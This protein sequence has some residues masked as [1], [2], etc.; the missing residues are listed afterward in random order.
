M[1]DWISLNEGEPY[2]IEGKHWEGGGAEYFS[3]AVEIENNVLPGHH[4]AIREQQYLGVT[5]DQQFD[6]TRITITD[7]DDGEFILVFKNP[8]DQSSHES[9]S[10]SAKTTP[11]NLSEMTK[12]YYKRSSYINCDINIEH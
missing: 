9:G 5:T 8:N 2:Y 11:W 4:H 10:I 12:W 3:A 7:M 6:R 1:S